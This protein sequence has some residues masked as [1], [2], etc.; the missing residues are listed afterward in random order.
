MYHRRLLPIHPCHCW[1]YCSTEWLQTCSSL[2]KLQVG[3]AGS[4]R[5]TYKSIYF[6]QSPHVHK[7]DP[8]ALSVQHAQY[9][10]ISN[11]TSGGSCMMS[12]M[13]H[14]WYMHTNFS[15]ES[16]SIIDDVADAFCN[17][18]YLFHE[19]QH[20]IRNF[21]VTTSVSVTLH[22]CMYPYHLQDYWNATTS[23]IVPHGT[24]VMVTSAFS[25]IQ[26]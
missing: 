24:T 14:T 1:F 17:I 23:S 5:S 11:H 18:E 19:N 26:A 25:S 15:I 6:T 21:I 22:L 12:L 4:N 16:C 3:H 20:P 8:C 9:V 7:L 13:K 10:T 2:Q